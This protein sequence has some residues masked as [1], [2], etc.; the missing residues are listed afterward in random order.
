[1]REERRRR[2]SGRE[3][4]SVR[5]CRVE[6]IRR[7][8]SENKTDERSPTDV[9]R[10]QDKKQHHHDDDEEVARYRPNG[11]CRMRYERTRL[12]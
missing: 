10:E 6:S 3:R 11:E 8:E 2:G 12:R 9:A 4:C 7:V 1:M 5:E